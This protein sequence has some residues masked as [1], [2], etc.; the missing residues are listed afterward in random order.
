M[1]QGIPFF[2]SRATP[3]RATAAIVT[4]RAVTHKTAIAT[5][6]TR[7]GTALATVGDIRQ[8]LLAFSSHVEHTQQQ[9]SHLEKELEAEHM[10][11]MHHDYR[12]LEARYAKLE[13]LYLAERMA[14]VLTEQKLRLDEAQ[15]AAKQQRWAVSGTMLIIGVPCALVGF[16]VAVARLFQV[17]AE[18]YGARLTQ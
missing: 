7:P 3:R 14:K 15:R 6:A 13:Q 2:S 16:L 1:P 5:P 4:P 9:V 11:S 18:T 8:Q 17:G 10:R 12:A